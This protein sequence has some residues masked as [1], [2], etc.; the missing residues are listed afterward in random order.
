[1][2]LL[3][4]AIVHNYVEMEYLLIINVMMLIIWMAMAV[5]L[6]VWWRRDGIVRLLVDDLCVLW[7][8]LFR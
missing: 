5:L 3:L 4:L 8:G 2:L 6:I 7:M 1:M